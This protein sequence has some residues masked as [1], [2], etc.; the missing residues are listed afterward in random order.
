MATDEYIVGYEIRA[1][2]IVDSITLWTNK[3][4]LGSFGGT[5]GKVK[6][7]RLARPG[8]SLSD[9][10]IEHTKFKNLI[11]V[12]NVSNPSWVPVANTKDWDDGAW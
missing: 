10:Q 4:G 2:A 8:E 1:G 12:S 11:V 6:E 9:I 5:G 3:R 7:K